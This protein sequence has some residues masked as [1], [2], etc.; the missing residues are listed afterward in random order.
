MKATD[1]TRAPGVQIGLALAMY[2]QTYE[3]WPMA[4]RCRCTR[5]QPGPAPMTSIGVTA[6][7]VIRTLVPNRPADRP[8]GLVVP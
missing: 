4:D 8:T 2:H 1:G 5:S 6:R 3:M 7:S